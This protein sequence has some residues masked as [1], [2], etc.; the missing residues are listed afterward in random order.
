MPDYVKSGR[1]SSFAFSA[2]LPS[3]I[4]FRSSAHSARRIREA[5]SVLRGSPERL[6]GPGVIWRTSREV[7]HTGGGRQRVGARS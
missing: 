3:A 6:A 4:V 2:S 1:D 5:G 7:E